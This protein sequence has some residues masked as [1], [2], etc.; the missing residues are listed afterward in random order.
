MPDYLLR[1]D[2]QDLDLAEVTSAAPLEIDDLIRVEKGAVYQVRHLVPPDPGQRHW[3]ARLFRVWDGVPPSPLG[4]AREPK[5]VHVS[6]EGEE[7]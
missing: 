4:S 5:V 3:V 7:V 6:T 2:G 1:L